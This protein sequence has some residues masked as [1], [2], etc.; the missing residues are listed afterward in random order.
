MLSPQVFKQATDGATGAAQKTV[1]LSIL[2]NVR[3]PRLSLTEQQDISQ[4]LA[5]LE[6]QAHRLAAVYSRKLV[7]LEELKQSLL[8]Q[9]FSGNL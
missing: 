7:A 9:A 3:V 2:R 1:S 4:Q 5:N 6:K 8:L